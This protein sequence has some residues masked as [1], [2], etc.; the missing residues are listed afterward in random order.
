MDYCC[1]LGRDI[2]FNDRVI[3]RTDNFSV[4]TALGPIGVEGYLLICSNEHHIGVGGMPSEFDEELG[5][6]LDRT[7]RLLADS[8]RSSV[9][10]FEHGPRLGCSTGGSCLDHAHLHVLPTNANLVNF[11]QEEGLRL[12]KAN[13]FGRLREIYDEGNGSYLM[14]EQGHER[15]VALV[16]NLPSQYLRRA[17]AV[18]EERD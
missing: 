15:F 17:I 14:I 8:Y 7:R 18:V 16:D 1:E 10:V 6:I 12:E 5:G 3:G 11:V 2:T 9:I 4:I 13:G